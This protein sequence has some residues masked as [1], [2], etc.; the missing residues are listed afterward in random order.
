MRRRDPN[1]DVRVKR[2]LLRCQWAIGLATAMVVL[3]VATT[4]VAKNFARPSEGRFAVT[5]ELGG[6]PQT[7]EIKGYVY[8][9]TGYS[10]TDVQILIERLDSAGR[11]VERHLGWV[12]GDI[13]PDGRAFFVARV[14]APSPTYRVTVQSYRVVKGGM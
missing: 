6:S 2:G 13:P 4:V 1:G 5:W 9:K 11:S 12:F 3:A 7:P 10:V 14:P 8:N